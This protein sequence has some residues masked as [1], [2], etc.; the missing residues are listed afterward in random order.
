[1]EYWACVARSVREIANSDQNK[2][3]KHELSFTIVSIFQLKQREY[4]SKLFNNVQIAFEKV[5]W[6]GH[7]NI[8]LITAYGGYEGHQYTQS[9]KILGKRI[10]NT[11]AKVSVC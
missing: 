9:Y 10:K 4:L 1:M 3:K 7:D 2:I 6:S 5:W 11:K 8:A